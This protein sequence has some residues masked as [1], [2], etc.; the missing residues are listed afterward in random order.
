MTIQTDGTGTTRGDGMNAIM[1]MATG[2]GAWLRG[3]TGGSRRSATRLGAGLVALVLGA[4]GAVAQTTVF[5]DTFTTSMG[6]AYTAAN[7]AIG[8]STVWSMNRSGVDMG[9]RID[10]GRL[11]LSNDASASANVNGWVFAY[12]D[13]STLSAPW[14]SSSLGANPGLVTW[15]FN[16]RQVRTDPSGFAAGNYGVAF[17]LAGTDNAAP[18]TAGSGYAVVLGQSG[19]TDPI[20]LASYNNGLR[21]TLTDLLTS[22]TSGLTDFGAEYL[23][24]RVTYD[25]ATHTWELFL[26]NDGASAFVDPT[27]GTL[28]SQGTVVNS[29]YTSTANPRYTGG[30]WNTAT[31]G[32]QPAY[33]DN[34]YLK[35][36]SA[37]TTTTTTTT[38]T[39][40]GT[41]TTTTTTTSTTT[42]STSTTTTTTSST[43]TTAPPFT[44]GNLAVL[45][46]DEVDSNSPAT[47]LEVTPTGTL[48]S[49]TAIPAT[50][51]SAIRISGSATS[52]GY[53]TRTDDGTLLVFPG[54]NNTDTT[55]NA[56]TLNP[57]A[58]VTLNV[59]RNVAI[60]T[61]YTGSSGN[62][63]RGAT[64][65]NNTTWFIG[66]QG[67]FY[68][69]GSTSADPSGNIRSV[70]AYGGTVYAFRSS[71][72][73]PP[74]STIS[75]ATGGTVT[76]L[77][78]LA[79][80]TSS[81]QDFAFVSSAGDDTYDILYVLE[82]TSATVGTIYK[83]SLVSGTWTA[84]GTYSTT[85]GGFGI[86]A[87]K[88]G[89]GATIYITTGTGATAVNHVRKIEDAA[90]HNAT[91]NITSAANI[92]TTGTGMTLK[93]ISFVPMGMAAEPTTQASAVNFTG[94]GVTAM[95]VNWTSGDGARRIVVVKQGGPVDWAPTDGTAPSGVSADFSLATDQGSGNKIAYD[96][97]G[98]TCTLSGLSGSTTYY[99]KIFEY[100]G[101]GVT[102]NYLTSGS[103]A[104]GNQV[105]DAA[106]FD[107]DSDIIRDT[108][109]TEPSD[110]A[111]ATYQAT[112]ITDVNS[113]EV[114]RFLIR[115][116]GAS[117]PDGDSQPTTLT[118]IAFSLSNHANL[119]RVALYDGTTE[120]AEEAA[121]ATVSFTGLNV[122]APDDGTKALTLR[123][124]FQSTVTD[125]EN[126]QFTVTSATADPAGS[127]FASPSAGGAASDTTGDRNRIEVTA[128]KLIFATHDTAVNIDA[129]FSATVE[130]RDA[131]ENV[132]LD[133]T[134]SVT[135]S[136]ATG[137]GALSA[138][139]GL[140]KSLSSGAQTWSDLQVDAADT[141]TL[142]ASGGS[143]TSA[144]SGNIVATAA[145]SLTEVVLPQFMQGISGTN[146]KRTPYAFRVTLNNLLPSATYRYFNQVVQAADTATANGAGN[147][148]IVTASSNFVRSTSPSMSSAGNYGEFT[149]DASGSY[150]GWF[151]TEA[152]GN[153]RFTQG[154]VVN[155]RIMLNDGA[156]GTAVATR[157]TT[158]SGV[159][160]QLYSTAG[161]D[162]GTG[163]RGTSAGAEKDF[164]LLFDNI[165]GTGRPIAATL[166]EADGVA[167]TTANSYVGFYNSPVN[168]E[169][170]SW[171]ALIPNALPNGI[172]RI[173]TRAKAD[174]ALVGSYT[175]AAGA[176]PS[177]ADT[178][179][180]SGGD[181]TP[182]V[183]TT[184]DA[185]LTTIEPNVEA[186]GLT[187][188][189]ATSTTLDFTW[190]AGNGA[191]RIVVAR[192]GGAPT[193]AP[194]DG[195]TYAANAS[196]GA[197]AAVGDGFVVYNGSGTG[198]TLTGLIGSTTYHLK[199]FEYNGSGADVNY[200]TSGTPASGSGTTDAPI[201]N[202]DSDIIRDTTFTEPSNV[203]YAAYQAADITDANSIEVARFLIRDGGASA[204]DGDTEPTTLNSI[205]FSLS[206]HA[207]LRRVALYDG[208]SE[209]AEV[210]AGVT[211]TF[212]GLTVAAPDD[213]TKAL[214]LR[215][216]FE[217]T[218]TD[219]DQFQ[220]AVTAASADPGGS[221]FA[222]GDAGAAAS[223]VTGDANRIEVTATKLAFASHD[224]TANVGTDFTATVEA[225]DA[226][227][228][229]DLDAGDAVTVTKATG[230]GNLTGG[231]AQ[232]LV[233]G[234][235]AFNAL[236]LDAV[237]SYTLTA[238]GGS[239]TDA[240]SGTITA[241]GFTAGNLAVVQAAASANNTTAAILEVDPTG[242]LV[243]STA[244]PGTG[245]D[246]IRIS[247]SASSTGYLTRSDDGT[248]LAFAGHNS[249][250]TGSN[251][252]TLNP[253]AVVTLGVNRNIVLQTTYT[254]TSGNQTRGATTLDNS[255]WFIGDQ[256]GFYSNGSTS[257]DPSGNIR[258]VK[259]Y[260]GTV[261]AFRSSTTLPPVATIDTPTGGAVTDLPG[262]ANGTSAMQ[263]FAL[264]S[265]AGDDT[266]DILY[267]LE[268]SSATVGTI[269]KHSLVSGSWTANGSYLTTV[270]GFGIV[271][272]K[273]GGGATIYITTGTGATTANHVRKIEDAAG[274]N[275]TINITSAV[276]IYTAPAGTIMKGISF[277][278]VAV[279]P[280][281]EPTTQ[282][283]DVSF[284]NVTQN[285]M[286]VSW[287]V[288][289]GAARLVI[290]RAGS[291]P[292]GAPVD[293]TVY[294]ANSDF[295]GSGSALA[296]GKVVYIG[297]GNSFTL[298]GLSPS[299]TY[300]VQVFE[301]NGAAGAINYLTTTDTGNPDSETTLPPN[302]AS[303]DI[304]R[305][306]TFT[307][308]SNI[309]YAAY[310]AADITDANSIAVAQ[311]LIRDGAGSPD[312]DSQPTT[313]TDITFSLSNSDNLR[314]VALYDGA[315][316][317][318]EVAAG[319]TVTF[320]G[321]TGLTASD[322]A[323]KAFTLR[324]TFQGTVTDNQNFQF[325][326]TS[327]TADPAGSTFAD[328][329]A[330]GASSDVTGD[331][332]RIVV[333][334]TLLAFSA[335]DTTVIVGA[336]FSATVQARDALGS[337]DLDATTSITITKATGP[338]ALTGGGALS[339]VAG[340]RTWSTLQLDAA[341]SYTL[342]A[343]GGS[344][345][346]ATS[347]TISVGDTLGAGDV[348]IIGYR[349]DA[350][351]GF[352]FVTWK[353]IAGGTT[354][355]FTDSGFFSDGTMRDSENIMSWTAPT[356]GLVPGSVVTV[357]GTV[358]NATPSVGT[359]IGTLDG[360][361]ATGDQ[362][363]IGS[364]APFP[365]LG[366][367]TI[368]GSTYTG[369]LL[370][371]FSFRNDWVASA[372][373]TGNSA[374]PAALSGLYQNQA[375]ASPYAFDNGQYT[376]MRNTELTWDAY[377]TKIHTATEW[378][379]ENTGTTVLNATP[380]ELAVPAAPP[381]VQA[382][383][384]IFSG[385]N[386]TLMDVSWT[387]GNGEGR[388]VI[389]REGSA[390]S[391]AP[392]DGTSYTADA[393]Y[394]GAGS[395]LGGG[396][397]VYIGAGNTFTLTGLAPTT[398]Y[399]LQV[400]EYN[401]AGGGRS[402]LTSAASGNPNSQVTASGP[403]FSPG[404][405][406]VYM[407]DG[408]GNA[409][410]SDAAIVKVLEYRGDGTL[411]QTV[412]L[413]SGSTGTR[414]TGSGTATS[415]GKLT[416][417]ENG[418]WVAVAGYDAAEDT[419][420]VAGTVNRTIGRINAENL[421]DV[422]LTT[423]GP[424]GGNDNA[425]GVAIDNSGTKLWGVL[426]GAN[427]VTATGRGLRYLDLGQETTGAQLANINT[428]GARIFGD[429]LYQ[430]GAA[431]GNHGVYTV[432]SNL[433]ES[434]SPTL[435]GLPGLHDD[436]GLDCYGL[437]MAD[438]NPSE[439]GYDTLWMARGTTGVTKYS[440]VGGIWYEVNTIDPG[441]VYH[442]DGWQNGGTVHLFIVEGVN[443]GA[444]RIMALTDSTGHNQPM[445]GAFGT[446]VTSGAN[447]AFRGV[448]VIPM[449]PTVFMFK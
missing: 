444:A 271:A 324:A 138:V 109:F 137:S 161:A 283:K 333:E 12:F 409:L 269:Y 345:T 357:S 175:V 431:V 71:T 291:A 96:G 261:Y 112:D 330:G 30:L 134:T 183:I 400:F 153:A 441:A 7:G 51:A 113:I 242:T 57:R 377:K 15:E 103:P 434:G 98:A 432:G 374:L 196:Y 59:S 426:H 173:E 446:V 439:P 181:A 140:T 250:V 129:D 155:M 415:E 259:A 55:S 350:T 159:T 61:T 287:T 136:K 74:V 101:S 355:Y 305:D 37:V 437:F 438:L 447:T 248:L 24:I 443:P 8:S 348:T 429:Q 380:F 224:T 246:A 54:H 141:Y 62:Q 300:H 243:S 23:S 423:T 384:I 240:T 421:L 445:S 257:A 41:S 281:A 378:T 114:A 160:V 267:V 435:T 234:V 125:N 102:A 418:R 236:Q 379:F 403:S 207:N 22:N 394:S 105:T 274:H 356:G 204:P 264:V 299:T 399:Y 395:A 116:G 442:I 184:A 35:V 148:I 208:T 123:A 322:G 168:E 188:G 386:P 77:P 78:G 273:N 75:A 176:W 16:M 179:N 79:N 32:T 339:L 221:T 132:D 323:D 244:I 342:T 366:D 288:G 117:A 53:L 73:F 370:Y 17:I 131:N 190:T 162:T 195:T 106:A 280:A 255:A 401:G 80:G 315:T 216:T 278:P 317:L 391:A 397:V 398:V 143:L 306:T 150:T 60:A 108:S 223:A 347:G 2:V 405:I 227:E 298:T 388:L 124:T 352:A 93:G 46:A 233:A 56:N 383:N 31:A 292:S 424:L 21:G 47:I 373:G 289:D 13:N 316:E 354:L 139:G 336:N 189:A 5:S 111:Y 11:D 372:T 226:N 126:F 433:P 368:P 82:A 83:H 133:A 262:L 219:N 304:I 156:S 182:I 239:L 229:V 145:P 310:Q 249:T 165:A 294:A 180:P 247:G 154:N 34:V 157:L 127:T 425:R 86:V 29:T 192:A 222:V 313:L 200:L 149:T 58:P 427:N 362:I 416:V 228:N 238:S 42:D 26:R 146:N 419:A 20:R 48:V 303:S 232:N 151:V 417:S 258:S 174:G 284:A 210:A 40:L 406:V 230:P 214:T 67:G 92:Y 265:S 63:T 412:E 95:T 209:L 309:D 202:N 193:G 152:T 410:G 279:T 107:D 251:A 45:R 121:G 344:L 25:P 84:N 332:N 118:D 327:A 185:R 371:G 135:I 52:S 338:G 436:T 44:A 325:T 172:R 282:A 169:A 275:T 39:T 72:S 194:V 212:T 66:D 225:R 205:S 199:V 14:V 408:N 381:T 245:T 28:V 359:C 186:S 382:Q 178:V 120:V 18:M 270:G 70:K 99:V 396:K 50:G 375:F 277:V 297:T 177:G 171:G 286:D 319:A 241:A 64:S 364:G 115:D 376:G 142:T 253:R 293:G 187:A 235:V 164:V 334:A 206:N 351:D 158:T 295:S 217:S 231:G 89:S 197:G 272:E 363:F 360:L 430:W 85:V 311:F 4:T 340:T 163:I 314:R 343:S 19:T 411:V 27:T 69:N 328:V 68:S 392:V 358:G 422:D 414:L 76:G 90:G 402:F 215:A 301:Y 43:T 201:Y 276:N 420:S 335:V 428:R 100:N 191:N 390:P 367:T 312:A 252:N 49:S 119:R 321:L 130:A 203:D 36:Q 6:A 1:K 290:A 329:D 104:E 385:V 81:M 268:A 331:R 449:K 440:L 91:I 349:G 254:G 260:G 87:V 365:S 65:L 88:N 33:F 308:P 296:G 361:A 218:V 3:G 266:Y 318:A 220:F 404:N 144:T 307:E 393:D 213:G 389:A 38:T 302:S 10:G 369:T 147:V 166:I 448:G 413:P 326:V 110:I 407:V 237:G 346:S 256:G 353:H 97:T 9:A 263:D 122:A 285:Q 167:Q 337:V 341:G 128:T 211:V 387:V 320:T 94:V 198:E 170:G